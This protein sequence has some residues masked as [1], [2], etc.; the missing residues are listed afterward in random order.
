MGR[1]LLTSNEDTHHAFDGNLAGP[2][3]ISTDSGFSTAKAAVLLKSLNAAGS[4]DSE[5]VDDVDLIELGFDTNPND[6]GT[7]ST[8]SPNTS[9]TDLFKGVWT[10]LSTE[11][12][13]AQDWNRGTLEDG[14]GG[15]FIFTLNF[16]MIHWVEKR[17]RQL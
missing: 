11:T 10:P 1:A 4:I 14:S 13:I 8:I 15:G 9:A 7:A 3:Y 17:Q 12:V 16:P 2:N 5:L 6:D